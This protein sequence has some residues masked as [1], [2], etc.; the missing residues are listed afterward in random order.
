[1]GLVTDPG[2]GVKRILRPVKEATGMDVDFQ[3]MDTEFIVTIP[4]KN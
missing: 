1:M 4:R 3:E 2:S